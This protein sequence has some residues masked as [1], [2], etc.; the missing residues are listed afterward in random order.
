MPMT[1]FM[2][3]SEGGGD[4]TDGGRRPRV[5]PRTLSCA[6][7]SDAR[8]SLEAGSLT[9]HFGSCPSQST[10]W[11]CRPHRALRWARMATQR[12]QIESRSYGWPNEKPPQMFAGVGVI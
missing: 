1:K 7:D 11:S 5:Q 12:L 4:Q 8:G 3:A 10:V 6:C 2:R 9:D